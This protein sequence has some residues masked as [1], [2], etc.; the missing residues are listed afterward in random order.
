MPIFMTT[1]NP[2]KAYYL[3]NDSWSCASDNHSANFKH[4][5]VHILY[6]RKPV[7]GKI[8]LGPV[9]TPIN[10]TG[11]LVITKDVLTDTPLRHRP[12]STTTHQNL[13]YAFS[14][15]YN[16]PTLRNRTMIIADRDNG[17]LEIAECLFYLY[18]EKEIPEDRL[19]KI[20]M[21]NT[22]SVKECFTTLTSSIMP[23]ILR[24]YPINVF[25][26]QSTNFPS[27]NVTAFGPWNGTGQFDNFAKSTLSFP[28]IQN[29]NVLK[30]Q[31]SQY[32]VVEFAQNVDT[33]PPY[34]A[35][36]FVLDT[37]ILNF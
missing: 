13:A 8:Y 7:P 18:A 12:A 11:E 29:G 30:V 26:V 32:L 37:L 4:D 36:H 22:A 1:K 2:P 21:S 20:G 24:N 3:H 5:E 10:Q 16:I 15:L 25:A 27:L 23:V 6:R 28:F 33:A 17:L 9:A 35:S 34:A 19:A 31:V 14:L